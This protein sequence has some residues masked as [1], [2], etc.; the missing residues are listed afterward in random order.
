MESHGALNRQV[1]QSVWRR[2]VG[3]L[4]RPRIKEF[5][6]EKLHEKLSRCDEIST[7]TMN[8]LRYA[9]PRHAGKMHHYFVPI[10]SLILFVEN[11]LDLPKDSISSSQMVSLA[12]HHKDNNGKRIFQLAVVEVPKPQEKDKPDLCVFIRANPTLVQHMGVSPI[13]QV[14]PGLQKMDVNEDDQQVREQNASALNKEEEQQRPDWQ[15]DPWSQP[16]SSWQPRPQPKKPRAQW[17]EN[18]WNE[19]R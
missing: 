6:A 18:K 10:L 4:V 13:G 19:K 17:T 11:A 3:Q 9:K 1:Q 8:I 14:L 15:R 16:S 2:G 5:L 12:A 7:T